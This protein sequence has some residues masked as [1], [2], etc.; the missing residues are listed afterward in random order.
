MKLFALEQLLELQ[1]V[2]ILEVLGEAAAIGD[3]LPDGRFQGAGNV[4]QG[5]PAVVSDSQIQGTVQLAAL[6]TAGGFAAGTGLLDQGTAQEGLLGDQLG[7]AAPGVAF[8][9]RAC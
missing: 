8:G 6:A 1:L 2:E 9:G 5:A 4:Q 7:E 3:A